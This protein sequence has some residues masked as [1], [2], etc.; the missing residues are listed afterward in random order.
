MTQTGGLDLLAGWTLFLL[1]LALLAYLILHPRP[2][3]AGQQ[4]G[5]PP[6]VAGSDPTMGG[7]AG[8]S[9]E[10]PG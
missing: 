2:R 3:P 8:L 4:S 5:R 1:L 10:E 6:D 9:S 7:S